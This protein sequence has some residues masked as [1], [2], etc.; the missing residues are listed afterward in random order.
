M[1]LC[2]IPPS[3]TDLSTGPTHPLWIQQTDIRP[4]YVDMVAV[5][6]GSSI[7]LSV[8]NRHPTADWEMD[9]RFDGYKVKGAELHE[10]YSDDLSASVSRSS[11]RLPINFMTRYLCMDVPRWSCEYR[12]SRCPF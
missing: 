2:W 4:A 3:L 9:L 5:L 8:L 1:G 11:S 7:R 6:V 12:D 10:M